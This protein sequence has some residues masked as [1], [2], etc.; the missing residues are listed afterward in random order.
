LAWFRR[1]L[2][3]WLTLAARLFGL[4]SF[5]GGARFFL[6]RLL[7]LVLALAAFAL[8]APGL[9]LLL[10]RRRRVDRNFQPDL[11]LDIQSS[12]T[13]VSCVGSSA[14]VSAPRHPNAIG[15]DR[16]VAGRVR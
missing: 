1:F 10:A 5:V 2:D 14:L 13:S 6:A 12:T 9:R 15:D 7:R 8:W 16:C 11:L 3:L 4:G